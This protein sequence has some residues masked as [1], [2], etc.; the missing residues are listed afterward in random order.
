M[1]EVKLGSCG[2][3][4]FAIWN[5]PF[6]LSWLAVLLVA[7]PLAT[8]ALTLGQIDD[9]QDA[10]SQN[11]QFGLGLVGN[12]ANGGPS[13][14]GDRYIQYTSSGGFGAGSRMV[15]FNSSQWLGDY[16][17]AGIT[18][19]AMDLN[20]LS[21]Q[22]LSMRLA[23]F[24]NSGTGY[25]STTPFSLAANSGWQHT[26]FSLSAANFTAI[27]SPGDFSTFLSSF[28]GQLRILSS[29]SLSLLGDPV[30][31]TLGIDNVQAIPEPSTLVMV[32]LGIGLGIALL[33]FRRTA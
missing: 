20:D 26:T 9:F 28:N 19:I 3:A 23:F 30:A 8:N 7:T 2:F 10:T 12:V 17:S 29:V 21:L 4:G 18:S 25:V 33:F 1:N 5:L 32:M 27:G 11:W 13:G 14:T 31:A 16:N 6:R 15:V 22:P 24:L